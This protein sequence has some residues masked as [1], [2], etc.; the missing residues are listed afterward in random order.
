MLK[1]E[2]NKLAVLWTSRDREI[3]L[4]MLFMYTLN[5]KMRNWWDEISLI[6]W[7]PSSKLLSVDIELQD[8]IKKIIEIGVKVEACKACADSYN[9]SNDLEK[10]GIEVKYMGEPLTDYL[11]N[12]WHIITI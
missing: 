5:G 12:G 2:N 7:G 6:I 11:K 3:A 8:Y 4:N 1:V 10:L 9:V